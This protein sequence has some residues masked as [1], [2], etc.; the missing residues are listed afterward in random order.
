MIIKTNRADLEAAGA[1]E[2]S[3]FLKNRFFQDTTNDATCR[4]YESWDD[5][6]CVVGHEGGI[7]LGS[8]NCNVPGCGC[9]S[10]SDSNPDA[11]VE[12]TTTTTTT[13]TTEAPASGSSDD[14]EAGKTKYAQFDDTHTMKKYCG[15]GDACPNN[16]VTARVFDDADK[17]A[18][19]K[20]HNDYRRR[21]AK[22]EET[23]ADNYLGDAQPGAT[24][25]VEM[26]WDDDL[27][28]V[29]QRYADQC[30]F[31]H[32]ENRNTPEYAAWPGVGQNAYI[33]S[34]WTSG[35]SSYNL[36]AA[37]DAWYAE[38]NYFNKASI[39][40]F[41]SVPSQ[42]GK[43]IGHY[44]QMVWASTKEVGCG[45]SVWTTSDNWT[46]TL[47]ICNYGAMGNI[48]N[49]P[50][51]EEGSAASNCPSGTSASDGLCA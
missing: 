10:D 39:S 48:L 2:A 42:A 22:G 1:I 6:Y 26:T 20:A 35:R 16:Q 33:S 11:E 40:S 49:Q 19:V 14:C 38:V 29:A 44:T 32:D 8:C 51:Y 28:E 3:W 45:Y 21:V 9:G 18:M 23:G 30:V 24:N 27:A 15:F 50:I 36:T 17:T 4:Y 34:S 43:M 37:A 41:K 46:K 31:G 13:T 5:H 47:V 25:M 7:A 12:V